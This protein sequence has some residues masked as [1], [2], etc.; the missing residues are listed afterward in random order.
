MSQ[1]GVLRPGHVCIRVMDMDEARTH[2][3]ERLGLIQTDEDDQGRGLRAIV[4]GALGVQTR[5]DGAEQ[6]GQEVV[7]LDRRCGREDRRRSRAGWGRAASAAPPAGG[8][9]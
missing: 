6:I 8:C 7:G 9:V 5:V 3:I 4:L 2:Y 1:S